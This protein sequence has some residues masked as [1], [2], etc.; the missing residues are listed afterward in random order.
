MNRQDRERL[1]IQAIVKLLPKLTR[2]E[3]IRL[4]KR[5]AQQR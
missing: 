1:V 4:G 2:R 3:W 5:E